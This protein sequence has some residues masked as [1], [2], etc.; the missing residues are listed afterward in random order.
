MGWA[1]IWRFI[2]DNWEWPAR[3]IAVAGLLFFLWQS[4]RSCILSYRLVRLFYIDDSRGE[5]SAIVSR[6]I[7]TIVADFSAALRQRGLFARTRMQLEFEIL[8]DA[9]ELKSF[10]SLNDER[11]YQGVMRSRQAARREVRRALR[12]WRGAQH[13]LVKEARE[14][15]RIET[16]DFIQNRSPEIVRY[17]ACLKILGAEDH[18]FLTKVE[19]AHGFVAPLHLIAGL[20]RRFDSDWQRVI[21]SFERDRLVFVKD[22]PLD[23]KTLTEIKALRDI[24]LFIYDCWILWGP[25]TPICQQACS[26][27]A[28]NWSSLQYGFGD[29]NNSVEIVGA[30]EHLR[31]A[32]RLLASTRTCLAATARVRGHIANS[33]FLPAEITDKFGAALATSFGADDDGRLLILVSDPALSE[34]GSE[35]KRRAREVRTVRSG[36][37]EL[38]AQGG[39]YYSAYLWAIFVVLREVPQ[40]ATSSGQAWVPANRSARH[41]RQSSAPWLDMIPFFEHGNIADPETL[42]FLKRQLAEKAISGLAKIVKQSGDEAAYPLRFA[43]ACSIDHSGCGVDLLFERDEH[44]TKAGGFAAGSLPDLMIAEI[45][46]KYPELAS[47]VFFDFYD[48]KEHPHASCKLPASIIQYFK[49]MEIED[50]AAS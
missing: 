26:E 8:Y 44:Q 16:P 41:P 37:I 35:E 22:E 42:E 18:Q 43:F 46:D 29:E 30:T 38:V 15:I 33:K 11:N 20:L 17:F 31:E 2:V 19:V 3:I 4:A 21:D 32:W 10:F 28:G 9:P 6:L 50:A 48:G 49:H 13:N 25:S 45:R 23:R 47:L 39:S 12:A 27:S 1:E 24:Q 14:I 40:A 5:F 7:S 36:S 34:G